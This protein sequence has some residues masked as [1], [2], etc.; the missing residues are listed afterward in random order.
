MSKIINYKIEK[1]LGTWQDSE[2]YWIKID[3]LDDEIN[4]SRSGNLKSEL[5]F[6]IF[7][8]DLSIL[9]YQEIGKDM[10]FIHTLS[11]K[12]DLI[13][14]DDWFDKQSNLFWQKCILTKRL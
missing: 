6:L 9:K 4:I 7:L 14:E 12:N 11:L 3:L 13:I 8:E 2:G 5:S 10:H 1:W